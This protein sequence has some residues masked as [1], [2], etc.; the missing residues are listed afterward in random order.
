M[1]WDILMGN[2]DCAKWLDNGKKGS[3]AE[4][5]RVVPIGI[6]NENKEQPLLN[7]ADATTSKN[8]K[9]SIDVDR[10]GRF[11]P[12]SGNGLSVGDLYPAGS[13]GARAVILFH[14]L[15][16][17]LDPKGFQDDVGPPPLSMPDTKKSD[18]NTKL[19]VDKCKDAIDG[20]K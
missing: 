6:T 7:P 17:K 2:N 5:M 1:I 13:F 8:P 12:D 20:K 10:W 18:E 4:I 11:Y 9:D 19:V 3:A 14:E 15:A 16:H